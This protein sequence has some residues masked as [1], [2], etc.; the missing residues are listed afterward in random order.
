M[1][2][3]TDDHLVGARWG[4]LCPLPEVVDL[5]A[6]QPGDRCLHDPSQRLEAVRG[7]EVGHI[8]QLGRKYSK[9]LEA[10]FTTE[11]GSEEALWMGCYGIGVSRLAQAA[12]EQHHDADGIRWPVAIAPYEVIVVIASWPGSAAGGAGANGSTGSCCRRASM[13]CSTIAPSGPG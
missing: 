12:V 6:A 3:G 4:D 13:S 5:R 9:A 8:F 2:T 10:R 11:T 1:P 7:I